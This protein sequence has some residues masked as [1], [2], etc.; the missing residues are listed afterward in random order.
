VRE[1]EIDVDAEDTNPAGWHHPRASGSH[2]A[3]NLTPRRCPVEGVEGE[4][5]DLVD[6][7]RLASF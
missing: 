5:D 3:T 7:Q 2:F 1:V 6:G 4:R